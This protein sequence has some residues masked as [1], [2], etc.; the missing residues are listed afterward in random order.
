[1]GGSLAARGG[2]NVLEPVVAGSPALFGPH[3]E[4]ARAGV[5]LV[6]AA[7]AGRRVASAEE[8]ARVLAEEWAPPEA[9]RARTVAARALLDRHRG[10]SQ[11]SAELVARVLRER[12]G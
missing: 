8:L 4:N 7:R 9:A 12:A 11:R 2:H 10:A 6:L 3:T 1:V 5:E